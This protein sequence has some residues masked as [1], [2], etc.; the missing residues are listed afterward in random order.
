MNKKAIKCL[1]AEEYW[2]RENLAKTFGGKRRRQNSEVQASLKRGEEKI[3]ALCRVL[4][5]L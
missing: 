2:K 3:N 1:A 5:R 4:A